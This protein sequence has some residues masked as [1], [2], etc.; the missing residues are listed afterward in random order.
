MNVVVVDASAALAWLLTSQR[1]VRSVAFLAEDVERKLHAPYILLWEVRNVL[2]SHERR[3]LLDAD[4]R[5]AAL[6]FLDDFEIDIAPSPSDA[7]LL[8]LAERARRTGLS[9]FDAAY[10]ELAIDLEC[11]I[12]TR[13]TGLVRA[14]RDAGLSCFDF[15]GE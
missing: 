4:E 14:A 3:G 10:L 11:A 8:L 15:L 1:T 5:I 12:A 13:D 9:L 6:E 7:A 2:I